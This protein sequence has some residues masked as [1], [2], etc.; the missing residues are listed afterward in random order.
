[1]FFYYIATTYRVQKLQSNSG[2]LCWCG[3]RWQLLKALGAW[4]NI[5]SNLKCIYSG[6]C[7][8]GSADSLQSVELLS[9]V[10]ESTQCQRW[11]KHMALLSEW[12]ALC[13]LLCA[14]IGK[15]AAMC[16][17]WAAS[18]TQSCGI[19]GVR[20]FQLWLLNDQCLT[21]GDEGRIDNADT[22]ISGVGQ[23]PV[24]CSSFSG[25]PWNY[26]KVWTIL[27]MNYGMAFTY[28]IC[29]VLF[30]SPF[31]LGVVFASFEDV[32]F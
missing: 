12:A 6:P 15:K 30:H 25:C 1:M 21:S 13:W 17:L 24:G 27:I 22:W 28:F 26:C 5:E 19:A 14:V 32:Y 2:T 23:L 18:L 31:P 29:F 3:C 16:L 11:G 20:D 8:G 9:L 4:E 7:C 10:C